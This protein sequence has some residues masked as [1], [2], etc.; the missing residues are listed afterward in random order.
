MAEPTIADLYTAILA[1]DAHLDRIDVRL[2]GVDARL[3]GID[4]RLDRVD[5]RLSG[6][7][8]R[9]DRV[10]QRLDRVEQ[11]L[12]RV[13]QRLDRVEQRL[14]QVEASV[15]DLTEIVRT[16]IGYT[17]RSFAQVYLTI[18]E[19]EFRLNARMDD[20]FAKLDVRLTRLEAGWQQIGLS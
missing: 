2:N 15:A 1:V 16:H 20:G 10:E 5:A 17:E 6:I 13:E 8:A 12:D 19:T 4:A 9:L 7:D 3:N 18:S 11:R 14:D